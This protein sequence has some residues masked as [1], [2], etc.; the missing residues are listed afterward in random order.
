ML[1]V[2]KGAEAVNTGAGK[3]EDWGVKAIDPKTLEVTLNAPTRISWNAD[4]PGDLS[5]HRASIES[6]A[7]TG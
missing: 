7:P 2:V 4:A 1:Y 6:S 5:V 3:P